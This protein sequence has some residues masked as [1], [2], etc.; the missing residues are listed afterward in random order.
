GALE[1][2]VPPGRGE[3]PTGLFFDPQTVEALVEAIGRFE[4][5]PAAFEPKALRR[6]AEAFD[7]PL[8]K[9]RIHAYLL[10][11]MREHGRC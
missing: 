7:R 2:V 5:D 8:F 3:P 4:A 11:K 6:R 10:D 1:T 9:E